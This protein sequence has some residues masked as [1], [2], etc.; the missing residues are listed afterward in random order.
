LEFHDISPLLSQRV[1]QAFVFGEARE[2]IRAAWS[3]F[4]PCNVFESL[5]EAV[6]EAAKLASAGD[7]VLFSPACSSLDQFRNYQ[8]RG[9]I[10]CETVKSISRGASGGN[11]N[12][13]GESDE[14]MK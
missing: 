2:K 14:P 12:A 1:K 11:P 3:L 10:F 4:T 13:M 8:Q 5:V 6:N 9:E 7:V